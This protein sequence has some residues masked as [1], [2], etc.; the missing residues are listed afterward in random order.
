MLFIKC[1]GWNCDL[2]SIVTNCNIYWK[3]V[4]Q[5]ALDYKMLKQIHP[6]AFH[7]IL[8]FR[9]TK[10]SKYT[11]ILHVVFN[12]ISHVFPRLSFRVMLNEYEPLSYYAITFPL[13]H[14]PMHPSSLICLWT[15]FLNNGSVSFA[16]GCVIHCPFYVTMN[17]LLPVLPFGCT[18]I[19][20]YICCFIFIC[21]QSN[22]CHRTQ[23]YRHSMQWYIAFILWGEHEC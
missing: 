17:Y 18:A 16:C 14:I 19:Y 9:Y 7:K 13:F 10:L 4:Q 12:T 23:T 20:C 21:Y 5:Q 3:C 8:Q 11:T 2:A 22:A 1:L 6:I 15:I